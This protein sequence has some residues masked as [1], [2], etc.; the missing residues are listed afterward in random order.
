MNGRVL[1]VEDDPDGRRSVTEAVAECGMQPTAVA[2][3]LAGVEA[4]RE[5]AFDVVLSDLVLPDID[6]LDVLGRIRQVNADIPVLIM[7][8][9][10]SVDSSVKALK[11][12]AY[13]YITKPLD[14]DDLQSKLNRA[15]ETYRLRSEVSR[16]KASVQDR[17]SLANFVAEAPAT[18]ALID[19]VRALAGTNATV[20]I[21]GE[22][23]T[24]KE[25][26]ARALHVEG[27]RAGQPFVAINCGAV[28]ESLLESELFGHEKG[29]FTGAIRQHRGAFERADKGT[30]F[31]DEIG[32]A[33]PAVQVKLLRV[34]EDR[35][36]T[37]V[38]S[39][40]TFTVDVRVISASNRNLQELAAEGAFREDLLYRLNVVPL[41]VPPLRARPADIRP[42]VDRFLAEACDTH[43]R[44]INDV[45]PAVYTVLERYAWPGNVR[46]L[47]NVI[48]SSVVMAHTT[49]LT[50]DD[51]QMPVPRRGEAPRVDTPEAVTF[52]TS[53]TLAQIEREIL[54]QTLDRNEGNRT[55]TAE[56]LGV[57][58]RTVQRKIKEHDLPF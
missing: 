4:F 57:S 29:S 33:P 16:L 20:L 6:G 41:T 58:R 24:G 43:G 45:A 26:I 42:L 30:L 38:G 25:L 56:Q 44:C 53:M 49:S 55:L 35:R 50:V 47:R 32:D 13:D 34:L 12:G 39:Q 18:R 15:A 37:R 52:P 31:L 7:T 54:R 1:I 48:E 9:Y 23:G 2:T 21:H 36:I 40:A 51:L 10:G 27:P 46:Q 5:G 3:G 14:L 11:A 22:S 17:Y 8:A 19:Q 28:P